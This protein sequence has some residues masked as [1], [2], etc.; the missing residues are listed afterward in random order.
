MHH[1]LQHQRPSPT[2][3][4]P[5]LNLI[6]TVFQTTMSYIIR[7]EIEGNRLP[8]STQVVIFMED[9]PKNKTTS[10]KYFKR[11]QHQIN[12]TTTSKQP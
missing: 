6:G 7:T 9:V 2:G 3:S 1:L 10:Q 8:K 5:K 12:H 4:T 11:Q